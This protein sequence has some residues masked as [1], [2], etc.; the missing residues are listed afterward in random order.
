ML[1]LKQRVYRK[2]GLFPG[3]RHTTEIFL[4]VCVQVADAM[5]AHSLHN[6]RGKASPKT[7]REASFLA[8]TTE[9]VARALKAG[10]LKELGKKVL[11]QFL[12]NM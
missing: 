7:V 5:H 9:Q 3:R 6:D 12:L 1:A 4:V 11:L 8:D 10:F 2:G